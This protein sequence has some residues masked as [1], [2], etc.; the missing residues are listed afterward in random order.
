M[1][2]IGAQS[3]AMADAVAEALGDLPLALEQAAA[4]V[5]AT[6]ISWADYLELFHQYRQNLLKE[7]QPL[8]YDA[9]VA[10]TWEISFQQVKTE[11]PAAV[12]LLNVC[13]FLAPDD[14]PRQ[15]LIE[16]RDHLPETL[17]QALAQPLVVNKAIASLVR[18]S[19][20]EATNETL[21]LHRLVQ[22]VIRDRMPEAMEKTWAATVIKLMA[23][24]FPHGKR[25]PDDV[26]F[27]PECKSLLPHVLTVADHAEKYGVE[28]K[29]VAALFNQTGLY[30]KSRAQYHEAEPL[31]R[32]AIAILEKT[33]GPEHPHT[34]TARKNLE[35]LL[36]KRS[37]K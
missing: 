37:H 11:A 30:L 26:R 23:E 1:R 22:A 9:T 15:L 12:D 4:Y 7:H 32:R 14:I 18:Y 16:G 27:W 29:K 19:L 8:A 20:I 21:S 31:Y 3:E 5:E 28:L 13:A 33:L 35:I 25:K 24:V 36:S 2:R 17:A 34:K 6:G 10:T